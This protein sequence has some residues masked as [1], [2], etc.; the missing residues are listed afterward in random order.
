MM[1]G[2]KYL[3]LVSPSNMLDHEN[4]T[5]GCSFMGHELGQQSSLEVPT[6]PAHFSDPVLQHSFTKSFTDTTKRWQSMVQGQER[7]WLHCW[8]Q[9]LGN[10]TL[11]ICCGENTL[12][13]NTCQRFAKHLLQNFRTQT[14][15]IFQNTDSV[16]SFTEVM[17]SPN[18][19]KLEEQP[20]DSK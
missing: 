2:Q 16:R 7:S 14:Q 5:K 1:R 11:S 6:L 10:Y 4:T 12:L 17:Q 13:R 19:L 8:S 3:K 9:I 20:Q 18:N 15:Q